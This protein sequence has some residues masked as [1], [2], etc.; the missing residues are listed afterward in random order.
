M[1]LFDNAV[2]PKENLVSELNKDR[3]FTRLLQHERNMIAGMGLGG[4]GSAKKKK[5][6][7]LLLEWQLCKAYAG[8]EDGK[9][10]IQL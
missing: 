1:K 9:L 4:A 2:V 3:T 8:E 5:I 10:R 7:L 6:K